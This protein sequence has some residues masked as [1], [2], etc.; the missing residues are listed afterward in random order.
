MTPTIPTENTAVS[1]ILKTDTRN[2]VVTPPERREALLDEFEHSGLSAA[3]FAALTGLK[4]PTFAA[5]VQQRRRRRAP[6]APP[7]AASD[8]TTA[9]RWL[10]AVVGP[11]PPPCSSDPRALLLPLPG[12][13]RLAVT[14]AGQV[15]LAVALLHALTPPTPC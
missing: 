2:R 12:G 6:D 1:P 9:V 15:P 13:S 4:Y 3:R 14:H 8:A 5:W 10:E 7:P 11:A